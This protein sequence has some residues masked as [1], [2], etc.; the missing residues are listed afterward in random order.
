MNVH[1]DSQQD[2]AANSLS[3]TEHGNNTLCVILARSELVMGREPP[4]G[5]QKVSFVLCVL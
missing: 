5:R 2:S 3:E 1:N 4:Q